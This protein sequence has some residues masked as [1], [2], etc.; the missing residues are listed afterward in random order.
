M[1][2]VLVVD[3]DP[4]IRDLLRMVL[5]WAGYAVETVS[6]GVAALEMLTHT[7]E[8]WIVLLDITM[9]HMTGP[10]VC[11]HLTAMGGPASRHVVILMT[12]GLF[13][14]GD[15]PP[16]VR[17]LLH[18]PFDLNAVQDL[19]AELAPRDADARDDSQSSISTSSYRIGRSLKRKIA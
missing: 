14:D 8:V 1:R 16:P 5:E 9:P 6:D 17:A 18:K 12:A 10:E 19:V 2:R 3:D 4:D 13:P 15:A 11:E 7:D